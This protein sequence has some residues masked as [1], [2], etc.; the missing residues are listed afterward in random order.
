M[1]DTEHDIASLEERLPQRGAEWHADLDDVFQD[2]EWRAR[3]P[4][5]DEHYEWPQDYDAILDMH[6]TGFGGGA[7]ATEDM[8]AR[9][10]R[11]AARGGG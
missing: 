8:R 7:D 10:R 5:D 3:R 9:R 1:G 2:G 11:A 4:G 6:A